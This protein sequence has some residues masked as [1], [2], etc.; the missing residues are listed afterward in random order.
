MLV[1]LYYLLAISLK[2]KLYILCWNKLDYHV[3][4]FL[5]RN[6][7]WSDLQ[8][9]DK[10]EKL[11]NLLWAIDIQANNRNSPISKKNPRPIASN[12]YRKNKLDWID[13]SA[14]A[15]WKYS[16]LKS[17]LDRIVPACPKVCVGTKPQRSTKYHTVSGG[18]EVYSPS[19]L[20]YNLILAR[21]SDS[22]HN[23]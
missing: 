10:A 13:S 5:D 21:K 12:K 9:G 11:C 17:G 20:L 14:K 7:C 2:L 18:D 22:G 8:L 1:M 23:L 6:I 19:S 16:M 4:I 15:A 3:F